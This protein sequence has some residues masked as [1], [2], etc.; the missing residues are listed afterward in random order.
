MNSEK[1]SLE[2]NEE[3]AILNINLDGNDKII[4][5]KKMKNCVKPN[6]KVCI[7]ESGT[8]KTPILSPVYGQVRSISNLNEKSIK[9]VI[10]ICQHEA[11]F[12]GMC[13]NCGVEMR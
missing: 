4:L 13:A 12:G 11:E 2:K 8:I 1:F 7:I 6:D 9:I 5:L 3:E 10:S